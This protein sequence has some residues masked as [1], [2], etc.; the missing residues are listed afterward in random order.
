MNYWEKLRLKRHWGKGSESQSRLRAPGSVIRANLPIW[1][2]LA[3]S[4]GGVGGVGGV[5]WGGCSLYNQ[6]G[7][8]PWLDFQTLAS[9]LQAS[10]LVVHPNSLPALSWPESS[11]SSWL[12]FFLGKNVKSKPRSHASLA[13]SDWEIWSTLIVWVSFHS[14]SL[15][16]TENVSKKFDPWHAWKSQWSKAVSPEAPFPFQNRSH[17]KPWHCT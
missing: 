4:I 3:L 10:Q 2:Y 6:I 7:T 1:Y 14:V 16:W 11:Q 8:K 5:G 13:W 12:Y 17:L 15:D 9:P